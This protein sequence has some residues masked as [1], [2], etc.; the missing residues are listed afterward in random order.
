MP[1][2]VE[3]VWVHP[4]CRGRYVPSADARFAYLGLAVDPLE[5]DHDD[6]VPMAA[7]SPEEHFARDFDS[8]GAKDFAAKLL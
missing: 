2:D 7:A 1:G 6:C 8:S 3:R 4:A 5:I